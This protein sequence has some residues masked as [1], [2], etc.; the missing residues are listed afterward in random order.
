MIVFADQ[1]AVMLW[2][3]VEGAYFLYFVKMWYSTFA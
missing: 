2:T 3:V 1:R